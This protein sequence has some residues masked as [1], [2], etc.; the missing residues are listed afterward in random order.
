MSHRFNNLVV[1]KIKSP[2]EK[3]KISSALKSLAVLLLTGIS[4]S[5]IFIFQG[6]AEGNKDEKPAIGEKGNLDEIVIPEDAN[7]VIKFAAAELQGYFKKITGKELQIKESDGKIINHRAIRFIIEDNKTIKW[8]GY[9]IEVTKKGITI[10]ARE[11]RAL[12]YAAYTLLE[13]AGCSFFYPGENEEIVPRHFMVEISPYIY[14]H[15]YNP[16]LEYRGLALYGLQANS[17]QQGRI[18]S[19]GWQ[20]IK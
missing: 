6:C 11:S 17:I 9:R 10:S 7:A 3:M 20:K 19:V 4:I 15:I 18:L 8:D 12:L 5:I 2:G 1:S 14:I 16:V 13:Q